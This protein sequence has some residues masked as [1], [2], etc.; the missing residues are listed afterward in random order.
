MSA[1]IERLQKVADYLDT[2]APAGSAFHHQ[3]VA[4]VREAI[5]KLQSVEAEA[6]QRGSD[7]A[8]ER[9]ITERC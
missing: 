1:L 7:D 2:V 9:W 3:M 6:Y 4:T 8:D 5:A